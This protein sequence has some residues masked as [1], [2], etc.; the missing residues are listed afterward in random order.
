MGKITA[1]KDAGDIVVVEG[2]AAGSYLAYTD[3]KTRRSRPALDRFRRTFIWVKD[4][5]ILVF[6]DV[7]SPE[8]VAVT[9]L[10]Q[11]AELEGL[12]EAQGRYRLAKND[13]QCDFH[14]VADVP[15]QAQ[16]G[17]ST[18]NDH[19]KLLNWQQLQ[20]TAEG[21]AVRFVSVFDPW[22]KGDLAVALTADGPDKAALT[23]TGTGVADTWQWEASAGRFAPAT[24]HGSREGGFDVAVDAKT[25]RPPAP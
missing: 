18:A 9:Y 19:S 24:W 15:L 11:G 20:A 14:L 10:V 6:D 3:R 2:E 17:T 16:I 21:T 4:D 12:D 8:A 7:R 1:F 13:A 25:A 5:Y 22:H 23:V